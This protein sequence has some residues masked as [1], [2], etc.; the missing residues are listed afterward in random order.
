MKWT[1]VIP[2]VTTPFEPS[3]AV[4]HNLLFQHNRV[5]NS[6]FEVQVGIVAAA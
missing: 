6:M 4:D 3:L 2:A 5:I 1:G